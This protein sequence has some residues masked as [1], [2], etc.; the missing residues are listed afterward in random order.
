MAAMMAIK[1]TKMAMLLATVT[2]RKTAVTMTMMMTRGTNI[3]VIV[4]M[5]MTMNMRC[6]LA[7]ALVFA[8]LRHN[9]RQPRVKT[10]AT[11]PCVLLESGRNRC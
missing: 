9:L 8:L 11:N 7:D 4:L 3:I 10:I 1:T 6:I 5:T 2:M